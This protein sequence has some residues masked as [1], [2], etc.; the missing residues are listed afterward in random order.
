MSTA[1]RSTFGNSISKTL[2]AVTVA[3]T[4]ARTLSFTPTEAPVGHPPLARGRKY[5][6]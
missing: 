2:F 6:V 3:M 5:A 4:D 1:L